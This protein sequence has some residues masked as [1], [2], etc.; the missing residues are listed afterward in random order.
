MEYSTKHDPNSRKAQIF[1]A[2]AEC[3]LFRKLAIGEVKEIA[4]AATAIRIKKG[5]SVFEIGDPADF[6]YIV[7]DGSVKLF[8]SYPS[9][10]NVTFAIAALGDTLNGA[11]LFA[12]TYFMSAQ[13][14]TD[15]ALLRISRKD[16]LR[17][18][19]KYQSIA[20][21]I[22]RLSA[23]RLKTEYERMM[24]IQTEE[25]EQRLS[26][27]LLALSSKFGPTFTLKR[28]E[29]ADYV[30]TTKETAIRVMS[31]LKREGIISC[32]AHRGE[33]VISN[34]PKLEAVVRGVSVL[35]KKRHWLFLREEA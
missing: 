1:Q 22:I 10:K 32:S 6:L 17:F 24:N 31:R 7:Q 26:E 30:G 28:E 15:S 34:L 8:G 14:V 19:G 4:E 25:V 16:F 23:W 33:V 9:G 35:N 12:K 2:V 27:C 3:P 18:L 20:V 21:Q 13:A 5:A 29:L 11:A